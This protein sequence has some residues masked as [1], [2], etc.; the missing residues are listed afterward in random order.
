VQ[1]V[2]GVQGEQ[3]TAARRDP[4]ADPSRLIEERD[5]TRSLEGL[6]GNLRCR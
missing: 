5:C 1:G 2:Q 6:R 3:G 4:E